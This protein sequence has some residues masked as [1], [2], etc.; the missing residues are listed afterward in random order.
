IRRYIAVDDLC[1]ERLVTEGGIPSTDIDVVLNFFDE[2]RFA[3]R[4]QLPA[5]ASRAL[6][7][8]NAFHEGAGLAILREACSERGIELETLG[9]QS[10]RVRD[11]PGD[12]LREFDVAFARGRSALEALAVGA[13]VVPCATDKI[14]PLVTT[15]NFSEL[16][17]LNFG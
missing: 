12:L 13:A 10:G 3:R 15:N 2:R 1:R 9:L 14:G 8:G 7:F 6:A 16:R 4:S 11:H 5:R 17:R